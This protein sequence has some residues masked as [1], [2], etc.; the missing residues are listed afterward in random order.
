MSLSAASTAASERNK[1]T[2][3]TAACLIIGDEVLGGKVSLSLRTIQD[4]YRWD[5]TV[6][7]EDSLLMTIPIVD[8]R[9]ELCI[10][11]EILLQSRD[12]PEA[13]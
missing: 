8:G 9:Y 7:K 10:H 13:H 3:N 2:I 1:K 5:G 12:Q 11:G 4:L 6:T